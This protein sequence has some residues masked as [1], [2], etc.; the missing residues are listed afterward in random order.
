MKY[1]IT[2]PGWWK[3]GVSPRIIWCEEKIGKRHVTW[4]ICNKPYDQSGTI[5]IFSK[6]EDAIMFALMWSGTIPP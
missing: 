2:V 6:E 1:T 4:D 3:G 5:F